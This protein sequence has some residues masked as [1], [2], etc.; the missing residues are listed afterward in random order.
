[1]AEFI[2]YRIMQAADRSI[3]QGRE[4]YLAYFPSHTARYEKWRPDVDEI[5]TVEGYSD[6]IPVED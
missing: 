5:L 1:M 2:A 6:V 3:E 4:K